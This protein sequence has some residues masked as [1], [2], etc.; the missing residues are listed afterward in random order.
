MRSVMRGPARSKRLFALLTAL[1]AL[2]GAQLGGSATAADRA[3]VARASAQGRSAEVARYHDASGRVTVA[4]FSELAQPPQEVWTDHRVQVTDPSMIAI[5]GGATGAEYPYGAYLT[6]SYP[7]ND[8]SSWIV[9]SKDHNGRRQPHELNGYAIGLKIEGVDR[10]QLRAWINSCST[11]RPSGAPAP[12]PQATAGINSDR[13]VLLG[14][15]FKVDWLGKGNIATASY[16]AMA[17]SSSSGS[18]WTVRSK[19]H[20]VDDPARITSYAMGIPKSLPVGTVLSRAFSG[21]GGAAQH[22]TATAQVDD[23]WSLTGAGARVFYHADGSLLWNLQPVVNDTQQYVTAASKDHD[24][25]DAASIVAW[26]IA[27]RLV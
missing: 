5:G 27:I 7:S 19:D 6:A 11:S 25:T 26:A 21:S 22:P 13:C 1:L 20:M 18:T 17:S 8:L 23:G 10:D 24:S 14:G 12:A 2:A 3:P 15:G 9:S 16:P 4:V